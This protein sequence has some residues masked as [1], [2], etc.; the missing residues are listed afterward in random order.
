[1]SMLYFKMLF[2]EAE[3]IVFEPDK[4]AFKCLDANV[5]IIHGHL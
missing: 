1:M 2:P 4:D 5:K 3:I